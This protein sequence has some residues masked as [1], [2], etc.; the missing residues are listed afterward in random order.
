VGFS[1]I[2]RRR[3]Y[4]S[5]RYLCGLI[6]PSRPIRASAALLVSGALALM[7][8]HCLLVGVVGL[9]VATLIEQWFKR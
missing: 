8:I 6:D 3:G 9:L 1:R 2:R 7:A 5:E 4:G